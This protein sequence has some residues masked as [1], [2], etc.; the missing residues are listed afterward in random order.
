MIRFKNE[1]DGRFDS[2]E[3]KRFAG[4]YW[5]VHSLQIPTSRTYSKGNNHE[6]MTKT[7]VG[8]LL[9]YKSSNIS[10]MGQDMTKV[11]IEDQ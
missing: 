4:P 3:N 11:T 10:E 5:D 1:S 8:W 6:I 9:A 7:W 2:N